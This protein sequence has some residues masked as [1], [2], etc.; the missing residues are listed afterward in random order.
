MTYVGLLKIIDPELN[1][2]VRPRHLA[3]LADWRRQH[4]VIMAGPFVDGSGGLVIW[5]AD[6]PDEA[7]QL[8]QED[9]VVASGARELTLIEWQPLDLDHMPT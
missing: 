2:K 6:T 1:Q 3:Y 4:K 8:A 5:S 9:P 7:R